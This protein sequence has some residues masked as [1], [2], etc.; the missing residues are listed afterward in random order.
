[1][2]IQQG[3]LFYQAQY[4]RVQISVIPGINYEQKKARIVFECDISIY[5][6]KNTIEPIAVKGSFQIAYIFLI[7]NLQQISK[8]IGSDPKQQYEVPD[9]LVPQLVKHSLFNFPWDNFYQVPREQCWI[10]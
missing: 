6:G 4:G 2:K 1:M 8:T 9:E 3:Y 7:E 5:K 10:K